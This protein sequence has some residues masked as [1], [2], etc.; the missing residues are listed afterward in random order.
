MRTFTLSLEVDDHDSPYLGFILR[1]DSAY[2]PVQNITQL[3]GGST[4]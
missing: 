3:V 4:L 1:T 2:T